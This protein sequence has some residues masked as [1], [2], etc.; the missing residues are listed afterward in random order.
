MYIYKYIPG[1]T[2]KERHMSKHPSNIDGEMETKRGKKSVDILELKVLIQKWK[3]KSLG[4]LIN[5]L[6]I[7]E[8]TGNF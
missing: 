6:D 7:A 8:I 3:I 5:I 4:R 1:L 2:R